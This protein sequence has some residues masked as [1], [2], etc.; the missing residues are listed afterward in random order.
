MA[1]NRAK[2]GLEK[3]SKIKKEDIKTTP[4][5]SISVKE[6]TFVLPI[7]TTVIDKDYMNK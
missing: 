2:C 5:R 3:A 6:A 4:T 1:L 7:P